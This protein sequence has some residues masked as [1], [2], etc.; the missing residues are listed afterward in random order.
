MYI[1][2]GETEEHLEMLEGG[3]IRQLLEEKWKTYARRRFFERLV[4]AVLHLICLSVAIYTRPGTDLLGPIDKTNIVSHLL[5]K[6]TCFTTVTYP[7]SFSLAF[8]N[9]IILTILKENFHIP[10]NNKISYLFY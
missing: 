7:S 8:P 1:T 6:H 5:G 9:T 4:L 2:D 3:V 10:H